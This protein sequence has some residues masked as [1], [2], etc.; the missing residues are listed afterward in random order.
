MA[1]FCKYIC[2]IYKYVALKGVRKLFDEMILEARCDRCYQSHQLRVNEQDYFDWKNGKHIQ[3]AM[4]Y[5][6]AS[7]RE[8]LISGICGECFEDLFD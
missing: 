2:T 8:V 6:P 1:S 7:E 3:E 5:I 4:P